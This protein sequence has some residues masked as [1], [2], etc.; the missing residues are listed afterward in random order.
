[1]L[2]MCPNCGVRFKT[3]NPNKVYHTSY[4]ASSYWYKKRKGIEMNPFCQ[5]CGGK[6]YKYYYNEDWVRYYCANC[7]YAELQLI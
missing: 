6:T 3:D 2:K 4:C 5:D 7:G 1:M